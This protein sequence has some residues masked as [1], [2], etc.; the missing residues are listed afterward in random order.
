MSK[1]KV[2][3]NAKCGR[4]LVFMEQYSGSKSRKV[5][6]NHVIGALKVVLGI[7]TPLTW[8]TQWKALKRKADS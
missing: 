4:N 3:E 1:I 6:K 7:W 2:G 5:V 8:S